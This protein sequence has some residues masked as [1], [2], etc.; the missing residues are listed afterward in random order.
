[1]F[2]RGLLRFLNHRIDLVVSLHVRRELQRSAQVVNPIVAIARE[3]VVDIARRLKVAVVLEK[4]NI[5]NPRVPSSKKNIRRRRAAAFTKIE[6]LLAHF[7]RGKQRRS[8]TLREDFLHVLK[9]EFRRGLLRCVLEKIERAAHR[10]LA[11]LPN[12]FDHRDLHDVFGF[13]IHAGRFDVD[14]EELV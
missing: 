7:R 1:M 9:V 4:R 13:R 14:H 6:D 8:V 10:P 5:E 2:R 3:L 12:H 11:I